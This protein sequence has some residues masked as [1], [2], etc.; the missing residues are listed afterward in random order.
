VRLGVS[1]LGEHHDDVARQLA[2]RDGDRFD[3]LSWTSTEYGAVLVDEASA[4]FDCSVEREI[5]AGDHDLI[6]LRVHGFGT[7]PG[8]TPL[9]FQA[10]RFHRLE[11]E[12]GD[13]GN[14]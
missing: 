9:V 8:V 11:V 2:S 12:L 5:S 6:L 4:W 1:V 13:G 7:A 10:S 14:R 3:G